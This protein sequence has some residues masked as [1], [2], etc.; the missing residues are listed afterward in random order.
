MFIKLNMNN[1]N[2][3]V[4]NRHIKF[5]KNIT[6]FEDLI[7]LKTINDTANAN[8]IINQHSKIEYHKFN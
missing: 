6:L 8:P 5:I 2:T 7:K 3:N 1:T 4:N